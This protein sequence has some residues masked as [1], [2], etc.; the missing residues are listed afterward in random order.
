MNAMGLRS[1]WNGAVN[2]DTVNTDIANTDVANT[3]V[4]NTENYMST[5]NLSQ[6]F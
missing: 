4:A 5:F 1:C 6:Y 2:T 3:D